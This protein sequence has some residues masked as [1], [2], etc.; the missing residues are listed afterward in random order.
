VLLKNSRDLILRLN[1][2]LGGG[3]GLG[4]GFSFSDGD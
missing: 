1:D 2:G 4:A 3:L